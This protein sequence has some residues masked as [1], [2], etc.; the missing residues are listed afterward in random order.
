MKAIFLDVDG[1]LVSFKTHAIPAS[2]V[3]AVKQAKANGHR[4]FIATGRPK[5]IINNLGAIEEYIDGYV[6]MNGGYCYVGGEILHRSVIPTSDVKAI[7]EYCKEKNVA[8]IF[9][10]EDKIGVVGIN[11]VVES[12]FYDHLNVPEIPKTTFEEAV[13]E[14][15]FQITPFIT[16]DQEEELRN[17]IPN[18]QPE[19]WNPAFVDIVAKGNNKES[20]IK[21]IQKHFSIKTEDTIAIGDGGNDTSM[22]AYAGVGVAMGNATDEVKAYADYVTTSVDEDGIMNALKYLNIIS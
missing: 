5:A 14:D 19:R 13:W 16:A 17:S 6:T 4:I 20:G 22:L 9:V 21:V 1:T 15:V 3:Q 11:D 12:I 7:S 18:C 8:T 10:N 2:T